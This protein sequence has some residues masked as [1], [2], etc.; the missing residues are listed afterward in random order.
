MA[1]LAASGVTTNDNYNEGGNNGKKFSV[2]EATVVLSSMG[3]T[4]N[5]IL[6]SAFSLTTISRSTTL[7]KTDNSAAYLT[8]PSADGTFLLVFPTAA[9]TPADVSGTFNITLHGKQ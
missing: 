8:A 5:K 9:D 2:I 4:T 3:G 6:A 1:S 7:V